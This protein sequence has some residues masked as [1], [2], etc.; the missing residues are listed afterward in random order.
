MIIGYC[1]LKMKVGRIYFRLVQLNKKVNFCLTKSCHIPTVL[2][3]KDLCQH[4]HEKDSSLHS[5]TNYLIALAEQIIKLSG[6]S[7][8]DAE[9][10]CGFDEWAAQTHQ[11]KSIQVQHKPTF[12]SSGSPPDK[13]WWRV[14][15]IWENIMLHVSCAYLHS[16]A[17]GFGRWRKGQVSIFYVHF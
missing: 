7:W 15:H 12:S 17:A 11:G 3:A 9:S 8:Q 2:S 10:L 1:S 16:R 4:I 6:A 13:I 5:C 14:E